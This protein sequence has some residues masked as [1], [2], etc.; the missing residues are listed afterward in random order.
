MAHPIPSTKKELIFKLH[1][2]GYHNAE[3]AQRAGC[4]RPVVT[5]TLQN[6]GLERNRYGSIE[7]RVTLRYAEKLAF[8]SARKHVKRLRERLVTIYEGSADTAVLDAIDALCEVEDA[9]GGIGRKR[10]KKSRRAA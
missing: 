5:N 8:Q 4:S 3:I 9:M 2:E 1:A 7:G 6:A 10:D